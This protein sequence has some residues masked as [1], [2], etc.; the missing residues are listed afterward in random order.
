LH[1]DLFRLED[2]A[3]GHELDEAV[4]QAGQGTLLLI[5]E[6]PERMLLTS[7]PH[8]FVLL[9]LIGNGNE[10]QAVFSVCSACSRHKF[11]EVLADSAKRVKLPVSV[12]ANE[13]PRADL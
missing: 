5:V 8:E 13:M 6:W 3:A 1:F 2:G 7:L 9:E 4:E 12:S 11:L 10:R